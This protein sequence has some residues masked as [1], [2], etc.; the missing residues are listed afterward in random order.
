M[1]AN[2]QRT[3]QQW[4]QIINQQA[5]SG[6]T[7]LTFCKQHS[8]TPSNFYTWRKRLTTP[9]AETLA[10]PSTGS[11]DNKQDWISLSQNKVPASSQWD[12][13]LTL[14]NGVILRMNQH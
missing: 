11:F 4:Q 3:Q 14:P 13:E 9:K 1:M 2:Q 12:I 6:L 8:I 5:S 10:P 7:V